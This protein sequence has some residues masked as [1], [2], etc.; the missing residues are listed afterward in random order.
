MRRLLLACLMMTPACGG[1]PKTQPIPEFPLKAMQSPHAR[2]IKLY[3]SPSGEVTKVAVN[4]SR[5]AL[6]AWVFALADEKL[7][8]GPDLEFEIE[9][10]GNGDEVYEIT[11][12]VQGRH[13][14]MAV[15]GTDKRFLYFEF[16]GLSIADLPAPVKAA[17]DA[18]PG[19][20]EVVEVVKQSRADGADRFTIKGRRHGV[21]VSLSFDPQGKKLTERRVLP[22]SIALSQ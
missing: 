9:Q 17:L 18:P 12:A 14:E 3:V 4:V 2:S 19:G 6:P 21:R 5:E 13:K 1:A 20:L 8:E 15:R 10:Y 7:G 16:K 11:R 22:G